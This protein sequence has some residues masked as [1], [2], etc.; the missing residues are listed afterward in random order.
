MKIVPRVVI[1]LFLVLAISGC[2]KSK[3]E[4]AIEALQAKVAAELTDPGSAQFR[5]I[6]LNAT[7]EFLCGEINGKNQMGGYVGFVPF[8]VSKDFEFIDSEHIAHFW[9]QQPAKA[10]DATGA[11]LRRSGCFA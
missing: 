3:D 10:D 11:T 5:N 7:K 6:K 1:S 8:A 9:V 4:L 2:G